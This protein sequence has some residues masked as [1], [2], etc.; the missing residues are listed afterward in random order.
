MG[1]FSMTS[2]RETLG[3][4]GRERWWLV[5]SQ[6][7]LGLFGVGQVLETIYRNVHREHKGIT[8][9]YMQFR[10]LF[11]Q[12]AI[13]DPLCTTLVLIVSCHRQE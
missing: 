3:V 10:R 6:M 7:E 5:R 12:S 4:T 8:N 2:E 11:V 1:N 13:L 9:K